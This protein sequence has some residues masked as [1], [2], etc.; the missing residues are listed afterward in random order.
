MI[1]ALIVFFF[2]YYYFLFFLSYVHYRK[3]ILWRELLLFIL[4]MY[5]IALLIL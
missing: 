3:Q 4:Q 1:Q 5:I 2:Y